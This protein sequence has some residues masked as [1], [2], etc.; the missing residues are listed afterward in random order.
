MT[1]DVH[2]TPE[3]LETVRKELDQLVRDKL[4]VTL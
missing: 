3:G 4:G 1:N 2:I